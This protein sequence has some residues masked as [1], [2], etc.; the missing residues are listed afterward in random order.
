MKHE[1]TANKKRYLEVRGKNSS[2]S[3]FIMRLAEQ[4]L[5]FSKLLYAKNKIT[6][7]PKSRKCL[8]SLSHTSRI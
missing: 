6:W 2:T 4:S 7:G 1:N 8:N 5:P 3:S